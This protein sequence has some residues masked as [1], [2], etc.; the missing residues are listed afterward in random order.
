MATTEKTSAKLTAKAPD[1]V[2][3]AQDGSGATVPACAV[4]SQVGSKH[5]EAARLRAL[6]RLDILDSSP[7]Q[8]FETVVELVRQVLHV[9]ICAVSL[10]DIDRQWF[11]AFRGLTATEGPRNTSFCTHA[12]TGG[13][14]FTV[15]DATKD[16]R[17]ADNPMVIGSP[18]IRSY[19]GIP[20][21]TADGY[22]IGS[23]CAIDVV[24]RK[25]SPAEIAIL[26]NFAALVMGQIELRQI[27]S[28]D[29]LTGIMSRRVWIDCAEREVLRA[30]RYGAALSFLMIDIDRFKA[31][32]DDYGH[33]A[34]DQVLKQVAE[35]ALAQLRESDWFG[36]YGGEEF[37]AALP[38]TN[39]A[40]AMTLAERIRAV[41]A[42]E[43][44]AVLGDKACTISI[45][46]AT[47][48]QHEANRKGALE[49]A[50]RAL[51]LAKAMGRNRVQVESCSAKP[52]SAR[53][54]A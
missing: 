38:E 48:G 24:P 40:E 19:A 7:E 27:A 9:P 18:H 42:A 45:G 41:I 52:P 3:S 10:I 35:V 6:A 12:I 53:A 20:L 11:K 1:R 39:L 44:F 28:T 23:L 5:E 47:L 14:A 2:L 25:F 16:W 46:I 29:V 17:F 32:N 34:G 51:Y 13:A 31:I 43:R 15:P 33:P 30:R 26:T 50:D 54:A 37:V 36:R 4:H 21:T 22:N 49:R 8:P